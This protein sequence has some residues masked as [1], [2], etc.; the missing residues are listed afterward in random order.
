VHARNFAQ[1]FA[2]KIM[3]DAK[4]SPLVAM[5]NKLA[6][7][8]PISFEDRAELLELPYASR[9]FEA[10]S[11]LVREG[12]TPDH[13]GMLASGL[14]CRHK[15]SGEGIRQI[16]SIQVP[17]DVFDLQQLYLG[18]ADHN[19]QTLTQCAVIT[20]PREALRKL[21]ADRLSIA[22]AIFA[23]VLVELSI[24]REWMLNIGRRDA[25]T[26][27]AHLL[28]E[29]AVRL[30]LSG[31]P[32]GQPYEMPMTQEQLGDALGLTAVHINRTLKGLV[33]DG[34]VNYSKRGVTIPNWKYLVEV[35]DF[36]SRYLHMDAH[37][38]ALKARPV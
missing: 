4:I 38:N 15:I 23:T 24:A 9:V 34:L 27:I 35:A 17:G 21:A 33:R 12:D 7:H 29:L 31:L 6:M 10:G 18:T 11:Y 14:V 8:A 37:C 36:N 5:L 13:C 32:P 22:Q 19:V 2:R 3:S 20:I 1:H 25:R 16:V 28:C 26:R 30:N